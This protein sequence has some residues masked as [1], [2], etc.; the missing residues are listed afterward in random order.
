MTAVTDTTEQV[1]GRDQVA[2]WRWDEALR[3]GFSPIL[4]Q[5]VMRHGEVDLHDLERMLKQGCEHGLAFDI[6]RDDSA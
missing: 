1:E 6:L 2:R 3:M 5:E 4:A